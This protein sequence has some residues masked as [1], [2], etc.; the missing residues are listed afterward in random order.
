MAKVKLGAKTLLYPMPTLLVG[1][2][3][4]GKPNFMTV[5][6]AGIF[7]HHPAMIILALGRQKHTVQGIHET[8]VFSVNMPSTKQLVETDFCGI[9]S[10]DRTDKSTIFDVFFGELGNAP[11]IAQCPMCLECK[12]YREIV[13]IPG[14]DSQFIGEIVESYIE[15]DCLT[16]GSPDLFKLDPIVFSMHENAYYRVGTLLGKAWE[17]GEQY[18]KEKKQL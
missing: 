12:L 8:G 13:D 6:Y 9:Y 2:M 18:D 4:G 10:G 7:Q 15:E 17:V 11:M 1:A 5:A 3:V 16:G 14:G